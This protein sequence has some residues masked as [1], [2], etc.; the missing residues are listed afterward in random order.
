MI[1][2]LTRLRDAYKRFFNSEEGKFL[3]DQIV[4]LKEANLHKSMDNNDVDFLCR[5]KGNQEAI[6]L[7]SNVLKSEVTPE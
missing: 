1:P 2:E 5:A 4:A 3:F 7:I 6:D